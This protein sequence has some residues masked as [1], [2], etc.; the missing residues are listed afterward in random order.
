[1]SH[2]A[3]F[4]EFFYLA[5]NVP[6]SVMLESIT[7]LQVAKAAAV[8][9]RALTLES[10]AYTTEKAKFDELFSTKIK[11]CFT[12]F[13][14]SFYPLPCH[15]ISLT[16]VCRLEIISARGITSSPQV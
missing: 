1:M 2:I 11:K 13:D 16:R 9:V 15:L 14:V 5:N 10:P 3:V 12:D 8:D 6:N 4:A 7:V